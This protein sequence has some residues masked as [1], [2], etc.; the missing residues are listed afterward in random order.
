MAHRLPHPDPEG[1]AEN[2][3]ELG[4]CMGELRDLIVNRENLYRVREL[5]RLGR[6]LDRLDPVWK[7]LVKLGQEGNWNKLFDRTS[8]FIGLTT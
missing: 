5:I 8:F 3:K 6:S 4:Q 7:D 1:H 2:L